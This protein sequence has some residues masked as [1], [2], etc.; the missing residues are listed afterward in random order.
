MKQ[1]IILLGDRKNTE[2][3][4]ILWK[5]FAVEQQKDV[6]IA[7][8]NVS[9]YIIMEENIPMSTMKREKLLN[10]GI[11]ADKIL[12]YC[13][14]IKNPN[15]SGIELFQAERVYNAYN[16]LWFGMSHSFAGLHEEMLKKQ[17]IY[18]FSAPSMDL[19]YHYQ[20]LKRLEKIYDFQKVKNIY[21]ELPYYCFNYDVSMC[22]DIFMQ[23]INFF[24]F[25]QEYHHFAETEKGMCQIYNFE[26]LNQLTDNTFYKTCLGTV[27]SVRNS[28]TAYYLDRFKKNVYYVLQNK[29]QHRWT[30]EERKKISQLRPHVWYKKH[31]KTV[32]ENRAIWEKI[33]ELIQKY[34]RI[35]VRVIVF[36]FCPYFINSHG[37]IIDEKRREF[38][39]NIALPSNK[40]MDMFDYFGNRPELFDDECHLNYLGAYLFSK[41]MNSML[42]E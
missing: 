21:F 4:K 38:M 23:R 18:K 32:E 30:D 24:Y 33:L 40:V 19:F 17:K 34:E 20:V 22:P 35:N 2:F 37:M 1:R 31:E 7:K 16:G 9:Y 26:T 10:I 27:R 3:E 29:R 41:R 42:K 11:P 6:N 15:K 12:E 14:F 5:N 39:E 25:F 28:A 8:E 13:H 36:P